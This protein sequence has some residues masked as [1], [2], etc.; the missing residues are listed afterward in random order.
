M[1]KDVAELWVKKLRSGKYEQTKYALQKE[2]AFCC[3]GVLCKIG[4]EHNISTNTNDMKLSGE[5][6]DTQKSIADWSGLR[7]VNGLFT[8]GLFTNDLLTGL[9]D[10]D[11]FNFNQIADVIERSWEE[12]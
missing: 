6:L 11:N 1:N 12:L 4:E 5:D 2:N 10:I 8:D 7:Y 3:L 9:N